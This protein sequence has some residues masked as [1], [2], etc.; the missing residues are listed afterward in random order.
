MVCNPACDPK[1]TLVCK[2]LNPNAK[3]AQSAAHLGGLARHTARKRLL[4]L[5]TLSL[6]LNAW[7]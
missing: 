3:S 2:C 6:S 7:A 4:G 5:V 1:D